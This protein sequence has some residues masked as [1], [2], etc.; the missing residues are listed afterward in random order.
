[1]EET[2]PRRENAYYRSAKTNPY[3]NP[4]HPRVVVEHGHVTMLRQI[5]PQFPVKERIYET[6]G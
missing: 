3:E 5:S 6:F 4:F 2:F 1:M